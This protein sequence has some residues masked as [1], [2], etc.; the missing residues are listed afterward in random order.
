MPTVKTS[1][2]IP[3]EIELGLVGE[4]KQT[5]LLLFSACNL[6]MWI[7]EKSAYA[8]NIITVALAVVLIAKDVGFLLSLVAVLACSWL[9]HIVA[10]NQLI[11]AHK[12]DVSMAIELI[13]GVMKEGGSNS[14][15]SWLT[16]KDR[17]IGRI[18]QEVV[19]K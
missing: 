12:N 18:I 4:S 10:R 6:L 16:I 2:S 3:E 11:L 5:A 7:D 14:V 1:L 15:A 17:K 8:S 19:S 13:R 9:S